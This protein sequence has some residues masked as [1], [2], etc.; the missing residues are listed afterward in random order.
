MPSDKKSRGKRTRKSKFHGNRFTKKAR[1]DCS[2]TCESVQNEHVI[3]IE[4]ESSKIEESKSK[5]QTTPSR[6]AIKL[7][8]NYDVSESPVDSAEENSDSGSDSEQAGREGLPYL[9]GGY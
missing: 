5:V 8:N 4:P 9:A 2:E 1:I 7:Y 3:E 6:S